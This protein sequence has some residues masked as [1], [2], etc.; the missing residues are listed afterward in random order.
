[1][2][3]TDGPPPPGRPGDRPG[4]PPAGPLG[5]APGPGHPLHP[6]PPRDMKTAP[7]VSTDEGGSFYF[8]LIRRRSGNSTR[9]VRRR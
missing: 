3:M 6:V 4:P 9:A 8:Q 1:M 7:F 2:D 5:P